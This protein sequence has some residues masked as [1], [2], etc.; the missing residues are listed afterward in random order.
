MERIIIDSSLG[1]TKVGTICMDFTN[2]DMSR[3]QTR[4]QVTGVE[5]M[6]QYEIGIDLRSDEGVLRCFCVANGRTI[7]VTTIGF[8]DLA[9]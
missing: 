3:F 2:V 1:V 4:R 7:G 6:L 5:Y 8:T 9:G